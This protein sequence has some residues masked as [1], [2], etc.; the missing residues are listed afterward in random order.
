MSAGNVMPPVEML[1]QDEEKIAAL[2]HM[3]YLATGLLLL[4]VVVF[5]TTRMLQ[6][7]YIWLA[8]V[9]AFAEAAIVGALADWFAVTAL[10]RHPFGLP[11]PHTAIIP[12]NK[13]RIGQSLGNFV[14]YNFLVPVNIANK[15]RAHNIARVIAQWLAAQPNSKLV[16]E[17]VC[18]LIPNLLS[19]VKDEDVQRFIQV[20]VTP[21]LKDIDITNITGNIL[22]MLTAN[23]RHQELLD[24]ALL[25]AER[26][27]T[28]HKQLVKEKFG[29][30]SKYTP[31]WV[32]SYIVDKLVEGAIALLHEINTDPEHVIRLQ[33]DEATKVFIDKLKNSP[34]YKEKG[35]ALKQELLD[36]FA[37]QKY[38]Q[39]LWRDLQ[40]WLLKDAVKSDSVIGSYVARAVSHTG[41]GLLRDEAMQHKLNE[42]IAVAVEGLILKRRHQVS[43]LIAETIK[44]WNTEMMTR[45]LE[46]QIGKDLQYIRINGTLVG[47]MVGLALHFIQ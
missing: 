38:Y 19:A 1:R 20:N 23:N 21:R 27:I 6:A 10:F 36:H 41:E 31:K 22:A 32:D 15:L 11:I 5:I 28:R 46:L 37:Q 29:Q 7:Q 25:A 9:R 39:N 42:W 47:G 3:K 45:K 14:E 40:D 44:G 26:L 30:Q 17:R 12:R 8:Y 18:G 43:N 34:E 2:R 24:Q 13:N 4:M 33:F 35:E 16:G